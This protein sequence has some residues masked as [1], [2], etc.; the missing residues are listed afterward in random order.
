MNQYLKSLDAHGQI[1]I[2]F[3]I[4]FG[5]LLLATTVTTIRSVLAKQNERESESAMG[6]DLALSHPYLDVLKTS[7]LITL[8]FWLGWSMGDKVATVMFGLMS[9]FALREFMTLSPTKRGDHRSLLL[10]F[11]VVLPMQY[12]FVM[13][14]HFDTFTVF[15]PVYVF[16]AIPVVSALSNDPEH[17][18]ERNA[19]MQWGIM[20]CIFGLSHVPAILLLHFPA[21]AVSN[22][23]GKN[24][25][26]L[27]HLVLV[28]QICMVVQHMSWH[29]LS[30]KKWGRPVA[31]NISASFNW[32]SWALGV[33]V[34][35]LVGGLLAGITPFIPAQAFAMSLIAC[36]AGSFGHLVMKALK[37][38]RGVTHWSG[39]AKSV[40]GAGGLLDRIDSLC[41]A[42]PVFFHS[43]RWYFDL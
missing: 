25:F 22:Y 27:F 37:R 3:I 11:F 36:V 8:I 20:V 28:V 33:C 39:G 32:P 30:Q 5:L 42:A 38:D 23:A 18:L 9:F 26:L 43:V 31:P 14:E 34:G 15:I 35:G 13:L 4:V 10:A 1:G 6:G 29:W 7:W 41:F 21:D 16:L 17:F 12:G 2:L 19:K 24:M 40:T